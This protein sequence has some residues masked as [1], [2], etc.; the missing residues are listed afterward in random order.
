MLRYLRLRAWGAIYR[1]VPSRPAFQ[2]TDHPEAPS[3]PLASGLMGRC[4]RCGKGLLF[5]GFLALRP[6]CERC[7]LDFSFAD[8]ADGPAFFRHVACRLHRRRLGSSS[9]S[10]VRTT[11]LG[12]RA[13]VGTADPH[14]DVVAIAPGQRTSD[15]AAI[16]LQGRRK[17]VYRRRSAVNAASAW[18]GP[19]FAVPAVFALVAVVI[20]IGLGSWQLQRKAW[21]EALIESLEQRLSAPPVDLPPRERWATL[22]PA[23]DEFRHVRFSAALLP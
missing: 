23:D 6:R 5:R 12:A 10:P 9:G 22:D 19:G 7:G 13:S 18:R 20:F 2:V 1:T 4:P 21:K 14:H 8:A 3:S 16:S 11:L 17:P 15:R